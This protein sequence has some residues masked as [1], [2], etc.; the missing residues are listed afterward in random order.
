MN[1]TCQDCLQ[2]LRVNNT[3]IDQAAAS[4]QSAIALRD[5]QYF[6][7]ITEEYNKQVQKGV[8]QEKL[9]FNQ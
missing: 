4:G 1:K 2:P 8:G 3:E 9:I 7:I 6:N 5:S